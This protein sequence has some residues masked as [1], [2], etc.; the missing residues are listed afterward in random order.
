MP[1]LQV[2]NPKHGEEGREPDELTEAEISRMTVATASALAA[3]LTN[4]PPMNV[5]YH[6]IEV[7]GY[8]PRKAL[9]LIIDGKHEQHPDYEANRQRHIREQ[10]AKSRTVRGEDRRG[11]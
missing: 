9:Q 8:R 7:P 1:V 11:R 2:D 6:G 4:D 5:D 3:R 10:R